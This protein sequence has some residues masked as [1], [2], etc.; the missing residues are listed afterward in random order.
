MPAFDPVRD[1]VLNSPVEQSKSPFLAP[2]RQ[3]SPA[4]QS[5]SMARRATD[6]AMLLNAD[7]APP[8]HR[9]NPSTLSHILHDDD[10]L[11][12]A[13]PLRRSAQH[14]ELPGSHFAYPPERSPSPGRLFP[15]SP[16]SRPSSSSSFAQPP[17]STARNT[18]SPAHVPSTLPYNPT[19]RITPPDSM[20]I[21]L[22]P[23]EM[24]MYRNFCGK[25]ASRLLKRKRSASD[26]PEQPSAKRH[27]G[28]VGVVVD[29]C[30]S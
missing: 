13:P 4:S 15:D 30:T 22:S 1:A 28:D 9:P 25:G 17:P 2:R 19:K 16:R 6:L 20:L 12:A 23:V 18:S 24:K 8:P 5:P 14:F 3:R 29:H 26:E 7:A 27:A 21:P 10:K 11:A